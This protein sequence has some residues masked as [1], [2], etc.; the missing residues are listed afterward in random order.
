MPAYNSAQDREM[1]AAAESLAKYGVN[2]VCPD[3]Y[4]SAESSRLAK[5]VEDLECRLTSLEER[6]GSVI[7]RRGDIEGEDAPDKPEPM[8]SPLAESLR[9]IN[10]R[11]D[12]LCQRISALTASVDL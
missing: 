2:Q 7:V 11:L 10:G 9:H 12:L 8:R 5:N 1:K 6:L 4:I 3:G